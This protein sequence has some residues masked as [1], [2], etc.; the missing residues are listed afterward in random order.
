[1]WLMTHK[2]GSGFP[3]FVAL[4]QGHHGLGRMAILACIT[5]FKGMSYRYD[6]TRKR[7]MTHTT[8]MV[9]SSLMR[10]PHRPQ[11]ETAVT[12]ETILPAGYRVRHLRARV[13]RR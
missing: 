9:T 5:A 11:Y 13:P 8:G 6:T 10:N 2:A 12:G 1:M 3:A 7:V 4:G